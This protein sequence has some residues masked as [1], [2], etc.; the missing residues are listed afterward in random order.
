MDTKI[1][2][3]PLRGARKTCIRRM[4][5]SKEIYLSDI[6]FLNLSSHATP[7]DETDSY[8][9]C[10]FALLIAIM[11]HG[12][13]PTY[14]PKFNGAQP[15]P[16]PSPTIRD[17]SCKQYVSE[18]CYDDNAMFTQYYS[19]RIF[20]ENHGVE[21]IRKENILGPYAKLRIIGS[22][23]ERERQKSR[24]EREELQAVV[25]IVRRRF[26]CT[27]EELNDSQ[28][29]VYQRSINQRERSLR[30]Q[31]HPSVKIATQF[32]TASVSWRS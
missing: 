9:Y 18:G 7:V 17:F 2:S 5:L 23:L 15:T 12:L 14:F 13:G 20:S 8:L 21:E 32:A 30:C 1:F 27:M 19:L 25:Q 10:L 3:T 26:L 29:S 28:D 6:L 4:V 31:G 11:V 16:G 22:F 24:Y